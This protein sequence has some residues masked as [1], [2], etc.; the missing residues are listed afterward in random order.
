MALPKL[1]PELSEAPEL[2][3]VQVSV[4]ISPLTQMFSVTIYFPKGYTFWLY[5]S[6]LSFLPGQAT[7]NLEISRSVKGFLTHWARLCIFCYKTDYGLVDGWH[8]IENLKGADTWCM[9]W[10]TVAAAQKA[11]GRLT[12]FINK[13]VS[14]SEKEA[15]TLGLGDCLRLSSQL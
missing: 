1:T 7:L 10:G 4:P 9:V 8:S 15:P 13:S 14:V 5:M 3:S 6:S 2:C 11:Q 12:E